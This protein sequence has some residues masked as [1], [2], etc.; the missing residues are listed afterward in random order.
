MALFTIII[1]VIYILIIGIAQLE[2]VYRIIS[3][4]VIGIIL[5]VTSII[6]TRIRVNKE[7]NTTN[8]GDKK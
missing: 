7:N 8:K 3:F 4:I 5:L 1:T 6:Y 2:P